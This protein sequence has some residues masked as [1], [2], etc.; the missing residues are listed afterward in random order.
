M[1][2]MV[3][4]LRQ[5][6]ECYGLMEC[7]HGLKILDREVFEWLVAAET[8]QTVDAI[9]AAVD[10][11]R[12]T[13]YRS[14]QRLIDAGFLEREQVNYAQGGYYHVFAPR[15]PD[16]IADEML[17]VLNDWYAK[18]GQLID[19]FREEYEHAGT[20]AATAHTGAD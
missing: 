13:A 19:E 20:D 17:R 15:H 9:A 3:D 18:M 11:E 10:R 8:P 16:E 1:D 4:Y 14:V 6:M 7:F 12:S 2:A 5:E